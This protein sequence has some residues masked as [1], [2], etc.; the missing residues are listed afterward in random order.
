M[1]DGQGSAML[2]GDEAYAGAT[3]FYKLVDAVHDV[4]GYEELIPTH[5]GRGA[6]HI[7]SQLLIKPGDVVPGNMYFTTT[8][9]HQE[10]AGGT[11]ADVIVDEAHRT[12]EGD[13]GRKMRQSLPNAFMFGLTGTP[14]SRKD[15]NTFVAFGDPDDDGG[16][17]NRYTYRQAIADEAILPVRFEPRLVKLR[18]DRKAIDAEFEELAR[19]AGAATDVKYKVM[20]GGPPLDGFVDYEE[21]LAGASNEEPADPG[22]GA[23]PHLQFRRRWRPVDGLDDAVGGADDQAPA[24]RRHPRGRGKTRRTRG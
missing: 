11:F 3:S 7:L 6:E 15:R 9:Y 23:L 24:D 2:L 20:L 8:R 19:A 13:L 21:L 22:S 4:Y 10:A 5:Q 18:V 16:Y 17:L 14:I 1:A 12:Q